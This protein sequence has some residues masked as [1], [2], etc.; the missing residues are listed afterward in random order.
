MSDSVCYFL[1]PLFPGVYSRRLSHIF[2]STPKFRA[3][4]SIE[5]PDGAS[6]IASFSAELPCDTKAIYLPSLPPMLREPSMPSLSRKTRMCR[7]TH[8]LSAISRPC[9]LQP[10][11]RCHRRALPT[12]GPGTTP[13][14]RHTAQATPSVESWRRNASPR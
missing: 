7:T 5:T 4:V 11:S 3:E 2:G 9:G 13:T 8:G 12:I 14:W 10:P 6:S 1:R